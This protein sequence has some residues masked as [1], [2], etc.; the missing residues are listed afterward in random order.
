MDLLIFDWFLSFFVY[1]N[2]FIGF[3]KFHWVLEF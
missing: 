1:Y 3:L 2:V